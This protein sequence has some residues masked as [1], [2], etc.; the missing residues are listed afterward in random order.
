MPVSH[1]ELENFKSYAGKHII[2]PFR[3]FTA[4][5]GPN[6]SGK[7]NLMDAISFVLGVQ[8]KQLRSQQ[9]KDLIYRP[10]LTESSKSTT[11][12]LRAEAALIYLH[13]KRTDHSDDD[14]DNDS[15]SSTID[16]DSS[17][18]FS[19]C[20]SPAGVGDYRINGK[21]VSYK[22]YE[23]RLEEIGVLV[24]A[25]NFLVFQGDVE[26]LARKT[27]T[28]LVTLFENVSGS[29][30]YKEDYEKAFQE[31]EQAEQEVLHLL[32]RQKNFKK[33]RRAL[34]EEKNEAERFHSLL[35]QKANLKTEVYLWQLYHIHQDQQERQQAAN[36]IRQEL[37]QLQEAE[38][39][40][41]D[42]LKLAKK[43]AS[44]ARRQHSQLEKK[45]LQAMGKMDDTLEPQMLKTQS[46]IQHLTKKI[47]Q[48][49]NELAQKQEEKEKQ[50]LRIQNLEKE[51]QEYQQ[52]KEDLEHE[53]EETKKKHASV[54]LTE[55]QEAEYE[56]VKEAA[57]SS[58]ADARRSLHRW[59]QQLESARAKAAQTQQAF[60]EGKRAM[61]EAE[62]EVQQFVERKEK[63]TN[64]SIW[65]KGH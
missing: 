14:D 6:G 43:E 10:P 28:E 22:E 41:T 57:A 16:R 7:S 55:E 21:T 60:E 33:E 45:R 32:R 24:Q 18:R 5:I 39:E 52:A 50:I 4:V 62:N 61:E 3:D 2:G 58:S 29:I 27:P 59:T 54:S 64:V 11:Q 42:A 23:G 56:R 47:D 48:D 15:S 38:Q 36:E 8:S 25:R 12:T 17:I 30:R 40:Q 13:E 31:K 9:L 44:A 26:A 46:E 51:I 53:Y 35:Q 20:I 63:L 37:K 34:K 19:R 65:A 1:L 49:E